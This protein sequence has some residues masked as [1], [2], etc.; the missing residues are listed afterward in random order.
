MNIYIYTFL[1]S[2]VL[3]IFLLVFGIPILRIIKFGQSIRGDG[4]Q[5]HLSKKGT[6]TMGGIA[7]IIAT[8]IAFVYIVL[9][10][11]E[12]DNHDI[13]LLVMPLVMYSIIGFIDD[14]LIVVKRNNKG[15]SARAKMF[16]QI[17]WAALY[18]YVFIDKGMSS[19]INLFGLMIDLKW[20]YGILILLMLVSSSNAVN[21][22]DGLDGLASGLMVIALLAVVV[23]SVYQKNTSVIIFSICLLGALL[24][25]LCYNFKPA[26]V[27]MGNTGS[28][29]LGATLANMFILLK[30]E[31]L[32]IIIG[33][34][35]V[36][37]TLSVIIQVGYFKLTKG[38]RIFKMAPL[39]HHYELKGYQEVEVDLLFWFFGI[40]SAVIGIILGIKVFM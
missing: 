7:I 30:M 29:A 3:S 34:V 38:K 6:P 1:I 21:L 19:E 11:V 17:I 16:F 23:I 13:L 40:L 2:F 5:S 14:Y 37:E 9:N 28:L 36:L 26:K 27:F 35:F 4:P 25:F 10:K 31:V 20:G 24:G 22:S 18:Y 32:L 33:F 39:H 8:I 15:I 12:I